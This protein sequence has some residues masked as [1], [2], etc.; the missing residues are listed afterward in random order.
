[1]HHHRRHC[2]AVAIIAL[3]LLSLHCCRHHC[4]VPLLLPIWA[5]HGLLFV[6]HYTTSTYAMSLP[7]MTPSCHVP[8]IDD[9]DATSPLMTTIYATSPLMMTPRHHVTANTDPQPP[10]HVDDGP[11][12]HHNGSPSPP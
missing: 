6:K 4:R 8:A 7:P 5:K 9:P 2:T 10:R 3:P 11:L 12:P 1:L